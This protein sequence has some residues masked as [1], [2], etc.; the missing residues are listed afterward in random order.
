MSVSVAGPAVD[1]VGTGEAD[2]GVGAGP[3]IDDVGARDAG[4]GVGMGAAGDGEAV[5][6]APR[7]IVTPARQRRRYRL[8][9]DQRSRRRPR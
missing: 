1:L 4:D 5:A 6:L 2:D 3:G 8:D 9:V 7:L